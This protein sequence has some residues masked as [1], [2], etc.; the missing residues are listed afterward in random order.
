[1]TFSN[2]PT[3]RLASA[4]QHSWTIKR[5][6]DADLRDTYNFDL[7]N[8]AV[9]VISALLTGLSML[10]LADIVFR[11]I[12]RAT[13]SSASTHAIVRE[14]LLS[15]AAN[16]L[17]WTTFIVCC[18]T[19]RRPS[20]V[21]PDALHP[22]RKCFTAT[23]NPSAPCVPRSHRVAIVFTGVLLSVAQLLL[24]FLATT[25]ET[26]VHVDKRAI[27]SIALETR[28]DRSFVHFST[29]SCIPLTL[30]SRPGLSSRSALQICHF[31]ELAAMEPVSRKHRARVTF[32]LRTTV[33][34][35]LEFTV[36]TF[37]LAWTLSQMS[38]LVL[39][40]GT[41]YT[42]RTLI[43]QA[44]VVEVYSTAFRRRGYE[45]VSVLQSGTEGI[46]SGAGSANVNNSDV[47]WRVEF[48][49]KLNA[50]DL[51]PRFL[52]GPPDTVV[53]GSYQ[54]THLSN[55]WN[56]Y[57]VAVVRGQMG[58]HARAEAR[59]LGRNGSFLHEVDTPLVIRRRPWLSVVACIALC[60]ALIIVW[61]PIAVIRRW[62]P[63]VDH[64]A[65]WCQVFE[66]S[67]QSG[68]DF[69]KR[70]EQIVYRPEREGL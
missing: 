68:K 18:S 29:D 12:V 57:L 13:R 25:R 60:A 20:H 23:S 6:L 7:S 17:Y 27:P 33:P 63:F 67:L 4:P 55:A 35:V 52:R 21:P 58:L 47:A 8:D 69:G 70:P 22:T 59:E 36:R 38:V 64:D 28:S 56:V 66:G 41:R 32:Q 1:M 43:S 40:D 9:A 65:A 19:C 30:F 50:S 26:T 53:S 31:R 11:L 44:E 42:T 46:G 37:R 15:R 61:V 3:T 51:D 24:I 10:L 39:D 2:H 45:L 48:D 16:P 34:E 5:L 54:Q 62:R 49:L 14:S